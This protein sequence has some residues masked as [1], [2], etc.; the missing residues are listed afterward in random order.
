MS[1]LAP[2]VLALGV[3]AA[4]AVVAL[5]LLSSRR[6]PAAPLPTARFVPVSEARAVSRSAL[7]TDLPLL[8]LRALAALL[9]GAAFARPVLDAPGPA[10]RSVVLLD[11]SASVADAGAAAAAAREALTAG[12]ALVVFDTVARE[13]PA[14]SLAARGTG[15]PRAAPGILSAAFVAARRAGARIAAGADSVRLVVVSPVAAEEL[16]AATATLRRAWPGGARLVRVAAA[17]DTARGRPVRLDTP[18]ADDPLAPALARLGAPPGGH[19]VRLLRRATDAAPDATLDA[20]PDA[21]ADGT[22]LVHWPLPAQEAAGPDAVTAFGARTATLVAPLAR[23]PL[24]TARATRVVARWRDG[25]P[26][27]VERATAAGCRRDV[28]VGLPPAGDVTLRPAFAAFLAA[29]VEPCGGARGVAVPD[30]LVPWRTDETGAAPAA[31]LAAATA[32]DGR[33]AAWLLALALLALAGEWLLRRRGR[34]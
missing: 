18:L 3:A 12:G 11:R 13:W 30:S 10:V 31:A 23:L 28:G 27:V 33:L 20:A 29:L 25:A 21:S 4:G 15:A 1:F 7:P 26:A 5:H 16:D 22:V 32:A 19:A 2:W 9:L 6:P 34:A 17:S 14:E 8:L 24:D